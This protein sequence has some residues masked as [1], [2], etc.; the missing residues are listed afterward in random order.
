[1]ESLPEPRA[2]TPPAPYEPNPILGWLYKRF[3]SRIYVDQKWSAVVRDSAQKGVVV[4]VM[5]SLSVLDFLCLDFLLKKFSL[6]L[7]T[8][9]NDLGLWILEPFGKGGRRLR[10][11]RQD[12]EDQTLRE[13]VK[14]SHSAL[15]FLRRPP[16]FARDDRKG[17]KLEVDLIRTLVETQRQM[18][19]AI[20]LV[21]Q[22][23]VW[24]KLP[25]LKNRSILG[26]IVGPSEGP[27]EIR[28]FFQFILN[29]RN[30]LLRSGEPFDLRAFLAQHQELTDAEAADKIRYALLRRMERERTLVLGPSKKTPARMRE[31][32][33][34][35]PRVKK[36]IDA[37]ART[38]KKTVD[39]VRK[40]AAK[41]LRRMAAAPDQFWMAVMH[42]ILARVWTRIY[43]GLVVDKK[44][45]E[46]LRDAARKG[47]IVLLPSHKSH[48]DYVVLSDVLYTNAIS[49]PL[50]A[51]GENLSFWP[52]GPILRRAGGF[53]IRRSF[54]GKR[55]YSA[56]VDAYVRKLMV[57]GFALEF[58]IEGGRSRTGKLLA[59]KLGLLSMIVDAA[60]LLR[61]RKTFFVPISIG[62]ERII[63]EG[64]YVHEQSGGEKSEENVG[65]LLTTPR[66]L[67][68][69]YGRLYIQVGEILSFDD[70]L[71]ET[72]GRPAEE[73]AGSLTPSQRRA[74]V[75]T[76]A[77]R[78]VYEIDRAT[79]VTPAALVA[80]ALLA[81]RKRGITLRELADSCEQLIAALLRVH[82]R[83]G[84]NLVDDKG[85]LRIPVL[86]G[87]L[88]L[89]IDG[90]LVTEQSVGGPPVFTIPEERRMALEYYKNNLLHF[91]VPSALIATALLVDAVALPTET[92]LRERVKRLSRTFK[93][94][95]MYRAD[96]DFDQIFD[97]ALQSMLDADELERFADR[98]R[99]GGGRAGQRITMYAALL[100]TYLESYRIALRSAE[101]LIN[102]PASKKEW[103]RRT[104]SLGSHMYL[105]G[106]IEH[107][108]S[109]SRPKMEN[110]LAAMH[111]IGLVS[112][113]AGNTVEAGEPLR[114][115]E[116]VRQLEA[117]LTSF[118]A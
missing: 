69:R 6:P 76:L 99:V 96:A 35:S 29:F 56:L 43:D 33:L 52:L 30:A 31:E 98:I 61:S 90:K 91:F 106:E 17:G 104:L 85:A 89:F 108:E 67:R 54:A 83:I 87:A 60:L 79:M 23:F 78:V 72:A 26:L 112:F 113:R 92:E 84:T 111:D 103:L 13:V 48:V 27:G 82:A 42:R 15:L 5:R 22:T 74:L 49:P 94:E 105:A 19:K 28:S 25:P 117:E 24:S 58:F 37:T 51:A 45:I 81:H 12:P 93:Y 4:Y 110:A 40:D 18:D 101:Q 16:S 55:L 66:I 53:F 68:S 50:I 44:G 9:V 21:P 73:A 88:R 57:E 2:S 97:E 8:F 63:E 11:R 80:A 41:D 14:E 7:V 39:R 36:H 38:S 100:R 115:K 116:T 102:A 32:I 3:F 77:H 20:L 46:R 109:I 118:V 65:G 1:M 64:A 59:P 34:R 71:A 95:F 75:Q 62:Y 47:N 10:L 107:R 86:E 114:S 70:V